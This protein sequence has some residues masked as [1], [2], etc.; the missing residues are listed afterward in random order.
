MRL[1]LITPF[2][3]A[4]ALVSAKRSK[5]VSLILVA[6]ARRL[7]LITIASQHFTP[8]TFECH[9]SPCDVSAAC[10]MGAGTP[11]MNSYLPAPCLE[12]S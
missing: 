3:A 11:I 8:K 2:I 10:H 12:P 7:T 5:E 9:G 6:S 1:T 4:A